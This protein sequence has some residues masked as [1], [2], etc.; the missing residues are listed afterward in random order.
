MDLYEYR[1]TVTPTAVYGSGTCDEE[2][3]WNK[4][5]G[6]RHEIPWKSNSLRDQQ[7]NINIVQKLHILNLKNTIL[8]Y[9]KNLPNI[10]TGKSMSIGIIISEFAKGIMRVATRKYFK[11]IDIIW[12]YE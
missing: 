10:N 6:S 8:E 1:A 11:R 5:A 12:A 9:T 2:K 7:S 4:D 3:Q